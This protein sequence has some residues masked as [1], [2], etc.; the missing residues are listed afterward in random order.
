M[1]GGSM[2]R[3]LLIASLSV[4]VIF[5]ALLCADEKKEPLQ[6]RGYIEVPQTKVTGQDARPSHVAQVVVET[7]LVEIHVGRMR[8]LGFDAPA[9]RNKPDAELRLIPL[10]DPDN[11]AA[12][13]QFIRSLQDNKLATIVAEPT[14]A[15]VDSRRVQ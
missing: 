3:L 14:V 9:L 15:T 6:V 8:S 4:G 11:A 12:I 10:G 5:T 7:K 13:Q 1:W 2:N